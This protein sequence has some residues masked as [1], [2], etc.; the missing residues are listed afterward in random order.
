MYFSAY[1]FDGESGLL[2]DA[3]QRLV[4]GLP[5]GQIDVQL[6]VSHHRGI[7][8]YDSCPSQEVAV[9]F[10]GDPGFRAALAGAGLPEPRFEPLG[11]VYA[12]HGVRSVP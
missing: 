7:T 3:Y 9:A 1:H 11:T 6:C 2:Q 4:A 10:A 8:V 5:D 12:A